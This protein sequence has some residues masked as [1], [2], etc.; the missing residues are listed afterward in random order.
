M[1]KEYIKPEIKVIQLPNFPLLTASHNYG[2]GGGNNDIND[3]IG[4]IDEEDEDF[5]M[6]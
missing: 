1:K 5:E 3:Q 4:G 2:M 6:G